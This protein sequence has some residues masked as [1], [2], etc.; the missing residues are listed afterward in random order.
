[1]D[2]E[3]VLRYAIKQG[4]NFD[5]PIDGEKS[6]EYGFAVNKGAN[7]ELLEMFNNGLAAL[8]KSG[9]YDKIVSKYLGSTDSKNQHH[10]ALMKQQFGDLSKQLLTIAYRS[11]NNS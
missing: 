10:Q 6:G 7:P 1:M 3:A 4:R 11:W 2:D 8:V 5:T 9:E